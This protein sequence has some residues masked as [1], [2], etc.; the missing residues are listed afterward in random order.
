MPDAP[1]TGAERVRPGG[2]IGKGRSR[3]ALEPTGQAVIRQGIEAGARRG[4]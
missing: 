2:A 1:A 4:L 3:E